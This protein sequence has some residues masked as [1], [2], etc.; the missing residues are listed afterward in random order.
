MDFEPTGMVLCGL[1]GETS[2]AGAAVGGEGGLLPI[3][4]DA[5][6]SLLDTARREAAEAIV[7]VLEGGIAVRP[8]DR[9]FCTR[10]C[11]FG[12]ICRVAWPQPSECGE[13]KGGAA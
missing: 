5:M 9:E 7:E 8:R 12:S 3:S 11:E 6:R 1:R 10:F 4:Q 13:S 2:V